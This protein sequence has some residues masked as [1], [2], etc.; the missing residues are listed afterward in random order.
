LETL[1]RFLRNHDKETDTRGKVATMEVAGGG[2][3]DID[4][5]VVGH[6]REW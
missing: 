3:G 4:L 5:G 6:Q 2:S 1:S